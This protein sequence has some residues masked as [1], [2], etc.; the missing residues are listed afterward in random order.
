[1]GRNPSIWWVAPAAGEAERQLLREPG[2]APLVLGPEVVAARGVLEVV[3]DRRRATPPRLPRFGRFS[4]TRRPRN[5]PG[6]PEHLERL[7]RAVP[8]EY[9]SA[10]LYAYGQKQHAKNGLWKVAP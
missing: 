1:M 10:A 6:S 4:R 8:T 2:V 3:E 7:K 5:S 9:S